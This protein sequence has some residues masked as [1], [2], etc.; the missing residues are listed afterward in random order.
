M[1]ISCQDIYSFIFKKVDIVMIAYGTVLLMLV[2]VNTLANVKLYF[3]QVAL[4]FKNVALQ[5]WDMAFLH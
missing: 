3:Y 4:L 1:T 2:H 5:Y